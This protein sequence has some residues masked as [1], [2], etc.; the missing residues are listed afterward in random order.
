[1]ERENLQII[2]PH[3]YYRQ[4]NGNNIE[5]SPDIGEIA[6][7]YVHGKAQQRHGFAYF[8]YQVVDTDKVDNLRWNGSY[9]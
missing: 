3:S 4:Y 2:L 7:E 5:N 8:S 9:S 1:M 6:S